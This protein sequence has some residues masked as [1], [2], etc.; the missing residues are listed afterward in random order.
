MIELTINLPPLVWAVNLI[1]KT[2]RY[3]GKF[4]CIKAF[5]ALHP[6]KKHLYLFKND[7]ERIVFEEDKDV[8]FADVKKAQKELYAMERI[9]ISMKFFYLLDLLAPLQEG[10]KLIVGFLSKIQLGLDEIHNIQLA[11]LANP[12]AWVYA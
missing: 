12:Q 8:S 1:N 11:S 2:T 5:F 3:F 9:K 10:G 4:H 6:Q 7:S